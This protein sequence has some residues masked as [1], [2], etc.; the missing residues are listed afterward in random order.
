M[1][2]HTINGLSSILPVLLFC[3]ATSI[4]PGPNNIMLMSS[5]ANYGI[6]KSVPHL[7]GINVGFPLMVIIVGLGF[8]SALLSY[9]AIYPVIK[10]AGISYL[11]F[12]AWKI[13][14]SSAPGAVGNSK[15]LTFIQALLF[16]W[17]NP[18]A[19]VMAIGAIAS[20]TSVEKYLVQ[21][22][23]IFC[24]YVVVGGLCMFFWLAVGV[25]LQKVLQKERHLL[26]FNRL[27]ASLLVLSIVPILFTEL[28]TQV[29]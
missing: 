1:P 8:G 10:T 22:L 14:H 9:P 25:S 28:A 27:M 6:K 13:A 20:F 4:T 3:F 2:T 21:M 26:F 17:V 19:W 29:K 16:Q 11:L 18:K 12:L 23:V 24:G 5:G 15:P 7:L